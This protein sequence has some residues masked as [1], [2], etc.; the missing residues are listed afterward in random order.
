MKQVKSVLFLNL[1]TFSQTG[2][3]EKFNK[4]FLKALTDLENEGLIKSESYS[5]YDNESDQKYYSKKKYKG[6]NKRF[7][8]FTLSA[9]FNAAKFDIIVLGHINLAV[10]GYFVK[11]LNPNKKLLIMAHGIEVWNDLTYFK[12]S[13]LKKSDLILAV[14]N[15]TKT[16]LIAQHNIKQNK[17]TIFSNTIDPFFEKPFS[18]SKN[19]LL[20]SRYAIKEDDFVLLT[21]TR[22]CSTEQ[23]SKGYV[24]V[25]KVLPELKKIIPNIKYIMAGKADE[26]EIKMVQSLLNELKLNDTVIMAGYIKDEELVAHYTTSDVFIMPSSKEGFGI[27]FIE[28]IACGLPVIAGNLDGSVDALE[29]GKLGILINPFSLSEIA[30]S[31]LTNYKQINNYNKEDKQNLQMMVYSTFGFGKYKERLIDILSPLS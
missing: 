31:I 18:F 29:G 12:F 27:V 20:K 1:T 9:I 5:V 24:S 14:S 3:I 6:F 21:I 26:A 11:L 4:C 8:Y 10:V 19:D 30:E 2:G 15:F 25:L 17:I 16:K 7:F 13:V 28:A 22:M 23:Q